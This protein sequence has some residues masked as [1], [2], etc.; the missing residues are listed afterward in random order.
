MANTAHKGVLR[1]LEL[2]KIP[3]PITILAKNNEAPKKPLDSPL[4]GA[5]DKDKDKDM[6]KDKDLL[7]VVSTKKN[8]TKKDAEEIYKLYPKK[9]AKEEGIKAIVKALAKVSKETLIEAVTA[10]G[11]ARKGADE[12]YTPNP[13]TWF[14]GARWEDDRDTWKQKEDRKMTFGLKGHSTHA[15]RHHGEHHEEECEIPDL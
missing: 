1:R 10:Y 2:A 12:K 15:T 14:N 4:L 13:A 6:D 5:Q 3:C 9:V 8:C 11:E 7:G